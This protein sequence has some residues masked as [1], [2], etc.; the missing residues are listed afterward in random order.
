[1]AAIYGY[2]EIYDYLDPLT[3][4]KTKKKEAKEELAKFYS[5][6]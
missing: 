6:S 2:Q 3:L 5:K 4:S 1:M